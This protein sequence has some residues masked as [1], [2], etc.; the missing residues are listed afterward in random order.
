MERGSGPGVIAHK[1]LPVTPADG[2]LLVFDARPRPV[3]HLQPTVSD[4]QLDVAATDDFRLGRF[5][6]AANEP[7]AA[8]PGRVQLGEN[9]PSP[10]DQRAIGSPW[11]YSHL[12]FRPHCFRSDS[13]KGLGLLLD[14]F[15]G[16]ILLISVVGAARNGFTK[17]VVRLVA[18]VVAVVVA[19]WG[20]GI[21]ALQLRPWIADASIAAVLAFALIFVGCL[22]VGVLVAGLLASVWEWGGLRWMDML[23]GGGF[24]LV[25]GMLVCGVVVLC[26][27]AFR[28]FE[29]VSNVV[30]ESRIAPWATNVARTA[31]ALAPQGLRRAFG[32][33]AAEV[34]EKRGGGNA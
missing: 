17:E 11:L 21:L 27:L 10:Q 14:I 24:G 25:R 20:H 13:R 34:E 30:A 5:A 7:D 26:L 19:M 16:L 2:R 1:L 4:R 32:Q 33:G 28:P 29:S 3:A 6:S 8:L 22:L 15:L 9:C 23:L 12:A 31:A 18:L